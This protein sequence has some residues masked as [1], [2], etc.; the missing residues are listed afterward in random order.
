MTEKRII[1][2]MGT[3]NDLYGQ[4]YTKA[5]RRAVQDALHHSSI[6]LFTKLG[7]DHTEMRVDVTIG[8]QEPDKVDCDL[9]AADLPRGRATVRAVFGG[10]DVDDHA[11][12]SKHVVATAAIEAWLPDQSGRYRLRS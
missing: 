7:I 2:E 6:T 5:A 4:D 1:L 12:G 8:V 10:L 9:V 11:D 3:G